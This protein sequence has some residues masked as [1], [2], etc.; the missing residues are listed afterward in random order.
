MNEL[1]RQNEL[2]IDKNNKILSFHYVT[3]FL[4]KKFKNYKDFFSYVLWSTQKGF[5]IQ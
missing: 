4:H 5:K 1:A 2:W 3:D